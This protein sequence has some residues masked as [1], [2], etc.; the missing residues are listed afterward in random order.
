MD[1][2]ASDHAVMHGLLS[3]QHNRRNL[4]LSHKRIHRNV[5]RGTRSISLLDRRGLINAPRFP[6]RKSSISPLPHHR[7]HDVDSADTLAMLMHLMK[8][9]DADDPFCAMF[10]PTTYKSTHH[11][12]SSMIWQHLQHTVPLRVQSF[13]RNNVGKVLLTLQYHADESKLSVD[14]VQIKDIIGRQNCGL[15]RYK[16]TTEIGHFIIGPQGNSVGAQHWKRIF[17]IPNISFSAWHTLTATINFPN[18]FL[19]M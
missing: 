18:K 2:I 12:S 6:T 19:K 3:F 11:H 15:S 10:L 4:N 1:E 14:I 5:N 13:S 9:D 16:K 8:K 17:S 7:R